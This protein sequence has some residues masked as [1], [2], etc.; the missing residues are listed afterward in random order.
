MAV[1][2]RIHVV[3]CACTYRRPA[4]LA[5]LLEGLAGQTFRQ[6]MPPRLSIII[7]DNE[8]SDVAKALCGQFN[9]YS[10][11]AIKYVHEPKRGISHARNRLLDEVAADCDFIAMIDDDEIPEPD[12][13]EQLL[14][15]QEHS[16]ADVV[17]GRVVPVFAED[18]PSWIVR[19]RYFGWHHDLNDAHASG[20]RVYPELDEARTNNVLIKGTAVRTLGF[21][22]D[23][24][25]GLSGGGDVV[26][27]RA[28]HAAGCRIVYA[29]DA[30]AREMIPLERTNLK[31]LWRRWYR[32]GANARFKRPV[33]R[34]PKAKL[35]RRIRSAWRSSGCAA[36]STGL[37]LLIAGLLRGRIHL[38]DLAPGIRSVAKGLGQ[39]ASAIGFRYEQYWIDA[40]ERVRNDPRHDAV[41]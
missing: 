8:G 13:I 9:L 25:F 33:R 19:G 41:H 30:R 20:E 17:E 6:L 4:G 38:G 14:E 31:W 35:K 24:R 15:A 21:R 29:P 12:W 32:V 40:G 37:A 27:F 18:A 2:R 26:F 36:V 28:L 22:F 10:G 3:V 34:E 11:I 5:A 7:A 23:P 39:A 16:R 1:P